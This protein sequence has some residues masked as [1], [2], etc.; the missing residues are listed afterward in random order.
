MYRINLLNSG[1][2]YKQ[3]QTKLNQTWIHSE[4]EKSETLQ[5]LKRRDKNQD[6]ILARWVT[7]G[8]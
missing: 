5:L 1:T 2:T 3:I 6:Q 4:M 8:S 7:W